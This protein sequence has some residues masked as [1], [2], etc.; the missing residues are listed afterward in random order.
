MRSLCTPSAQIRETKTRRSDAVWLFGSLLL[1]K[2][3]TS[4][5]QDE[6]THLL[7][8]LFTCATSL[9][10]TG[11]LVQ[12]QVAMAAMDCHAYDN[13][14]TLIQSINDRFPKSLRAA[15]LQGMFYELLGRWREAAELYDATLKDHPA[16][17][18]IWK[19]KVPTVV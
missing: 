7:L 18:Y 2:H 9:P 10:H 17:P 11:W 19:R 5:P 14:H 6:R 13:A 12:E 15:R 16:Q 1:T 4:L 3:A 8:T